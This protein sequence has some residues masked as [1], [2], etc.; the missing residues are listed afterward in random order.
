ME[1]VAVVVVV[2]VFCSKGFVSVVWELLTRL[3]VIVWFEADWFEAD[4]RAREWKVAGA[5]R[6]RRGLSRFGWEKRVR[7]TRVRWEV[8][9]L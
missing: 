1:A 8:R 4:L 7:W 3:D 6:L 9:L 2:V 5:K